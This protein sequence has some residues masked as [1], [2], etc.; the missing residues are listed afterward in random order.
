M[1]RNLDE[2]VQAVKQGPRRTAVVAAAQTE[3]AVEAAVMAKRE[4]M[5]DCILTGDK[6]VIESYVQKLAPEL[7]FE[8]VDTGAD[9]MAACVAAVNLIRAGK[10]QL[11]LKG[12]CDTGLLLKAVLDKERGL[13]TGRVMSDVLAYETP[14]RLMLMGDGGFLPLPTLE[15]KISVL[16]NCVHVAHA[17]GNPNPK[18]ALITHTEQVS[19]KIPST[20][21][22]AMITKMNQRGQIKGCMVEGPLALD[23]AIN[24]A[25]AQLKGIT[26]PVG[27]DADILVV[28]NIECGNLFGKTL[29]YYCKFRVAHV[30]MGAA[31]PV[32]IAS[33]A[34]EAEVKFHS[35]ALGIIA[36]G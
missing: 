32:L 1:I 26:S 9:M 30:V 8:I 21:D 19:P 15:E 5:A 27:G 6:A 31:A 16:Q 33:R 3:T 12:K 10:A 34:D 2:L 17:L 4:G 24:P 20:M 36:A 14:E 25:A 18:V 22:A 28:P 35:L 23:N 13:R 7:S 11:V 29:T